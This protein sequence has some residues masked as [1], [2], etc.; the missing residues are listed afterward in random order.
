MTRDIQ[1]AQQLSP[2][3]QL[4]EQKPAFAALIEQC[5]SGLNA[6]SQIQTRTPIRY[7]KPK[8]LAALQD[9]HHA[10][11]P[12][13]DYNA[14]ELTTAFFDAL[15]ALPHGVFIGD[16][17]GELGMLVRFVSH[18]ETIGEL[19]P[20]NQ[21]RDQ[22]VLL[23]DMI[24]RGADSCGVIN[25]VQY[26]LMKHYDCTLIMGNAE[27][28]ILNMQ[29]DETH[30]PIKDMTVFQSYFPGVDLEQAGI[31]RQQF[32]EC[33]QALGHGTFFNALTACTRL[34]PYIFSHS[35]DLPFKVW[36]AETDID[37]TIEQLALQ[38][39]ASFY[40][41][42]GNPRQCT[43]LSLF[44]TETLTRYY[45]Y[46]RHH[47][48]LGFTVVF[49]HMCF[50]RPT[51]VRHRG[52]IQA[53]GIDTDVNGLIE[54]DLLQ[55]PRKMLTGFL[56]QRQ[57]TLSLV[58]IIANDIKKGTPQPYFCTFDVAPEAALPM[59]PD[60]HQQCDATAQYYRTLSNHPF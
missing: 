26:Y 30:L 29:Q 31:N 12:L 21:P 37:N 19:V 58:E 48:A 7:D 9:C 40:H 34:G 44:N 59:S 17:Q 1:S 10:A 50:M 14:F 42:Q 55:G 22:V 39:P 13:P 38:E 47:Q 20:D 41:N 46:E 49:G 45:N 23:G 5:I 8:Q 18:L 24:S 36:V 43:T 3:D 25:Y 4:R 60:L 57:A 32:T 16:V 33:F 56:P 51:I 27:A 53:I 28:R 6:G 54:D 15:E 35:G 11:R 52:A 2:F